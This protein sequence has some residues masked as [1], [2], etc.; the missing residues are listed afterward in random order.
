[1]DNDILINQARDLYADLR[2]KQQMKP[3]DRIECLVASAYRR[4]QRRLNICVVCYQTRLNECDRF[5]LGKFC[6]HSSQ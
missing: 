5:I 4:Y 2:V 1:M 6:P 3:S